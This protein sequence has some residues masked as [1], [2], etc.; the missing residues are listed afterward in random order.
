MELTNVLVQM[1]KVSPGSPPPP[2]PPG[3]A[4]DKCITE[5]D[6]KMLLWP[7]MLPRQVA[8]GALVQLL[9]VKALFRVFVKAT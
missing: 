4:A 2:P 3:M 6:I 1:P 5:A 9:L 8:G 7:L